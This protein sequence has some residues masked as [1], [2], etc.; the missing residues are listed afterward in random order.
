VRAWVPSLNPLA[1]KTKQNKTKQNKTKKQQ[2]K[3]TNSIS[4][5]I[6]YFKK[7][8]LD[9]HFSIMGFLLPF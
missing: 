9:M 8:F 4:I 1:P 5:S 3:K 2:Q 7:I 6:P